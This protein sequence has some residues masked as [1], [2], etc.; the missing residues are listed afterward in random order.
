MMKLNINSYPRFKWQNPIIGGGEVVYCRGLKLV[1]IILKKKSFYF[2]FYAL[3]R[4]LYLQYLSICL[5]T[6]ECLIFNTAES[7]LTNDPSRLRPISHNRIIIFLKIQILTDY[8]LFYLLIFYFVLWVFNNWRFFLCQEIKKR[9]RKKKD[10]L[11][12]ELGWGH[13]GRSVWSQ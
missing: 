1:I 13:V 12:R 8:I 5:S 9:K 4:H 6:L 3:D 7:G 11:S 2:L 10:V